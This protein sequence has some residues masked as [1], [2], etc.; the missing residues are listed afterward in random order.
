M[1][2]YIYI[3]INIIYIYIYTYSAVYQHLRAGRRQLADFCTLSRCC[4]RFG[5]GAVIVHE[6]ARVPRRREGLCLC[7]LCLHTHVPKRRKK[8]NGHGVREEK[9]FKRECIL[10]VVFYFHGNGLTYLENWN[11]CTTNKKESLKNTNDCNNRVLCHFDDSTAFNTPHYARTRNA[12]AR[13]PNL[14]IFY[15]Y[16][17]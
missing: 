9:N 12:M 8:R 5:F 10:R 15:T 11:Y 6:K 13:Y 17:I 16:I 3:Y 7:H 2:T 14:E 4:F 1:H